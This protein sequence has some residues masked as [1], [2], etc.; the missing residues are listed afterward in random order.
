MANKQY[1]GARYVPLIDGEYNA[2]KSYEPLTVVIY[3]TNSYTSKKFVPAGVA[4]S[5]TDYWVMTGNYNAGIGMLSDRLDIVE[6]DVSNLKEAVDTLED[7]TIPALETEIDTAMN[8]RERNLSGRKFIIIGDSYGGLGWTTNVATRL[9]LDAHIINIGGAGFY[10]AGGGQ[11]FKDGLEAY[12]ETLTADER[13]LVTD[14]IVGGGVNDY[15]ETTGNIA[16][17]ITTFIT[18]AHTNF[19]NAKL[20]VACVSW[21]KRGNDIDGYVNRVI[22]TYRSKFTAYG[23]TYYIPNA[24]LPM[25]NYSNIDSDGI[26]PKSSGTEAITD[27]MC[28]YLLTGDAD[29]IVN[30]SPTVTPVGVTGTFAFN[31]KMSKEGIDVLFSGGTLTFTTPKTFNTWSGLTQIA[32]LAGGCVSGH[33]STGLSVTGTADFTM[34]VPCTYITTTEKTYDGT[35]LLSFY[36][37][38]VD[39]SGV[40]LDTNTTANTYGTA[41]MVVLGAATAHVGL[42]SS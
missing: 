9:N 27:F 32:S 21:M 18:F 34:V 12:A 25:H 40:C 4:P 23:Y 14:I 30:S 1:I 31:T 11:T 3:N 28:Q 20:G 24:Y 35:A 15:N 17:A 38:R 33:V 10:A 2:E 7:E 42:L 39:I 41:S 5:N 19:P 36:D 8:K 13:A 6:G 22:P 16:N 29:Y 26:H 37:G